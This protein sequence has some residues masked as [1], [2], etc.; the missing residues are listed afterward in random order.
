MIEFSFAC[1]LKPLVLNDQN[2]FVFFTRKIDPNLPRD[3]ARPGA[4]RGPGKRQDSPA[5]R[6]R[7]QLSRLRLRSLLKQLCE[8]LDSCDRR[9]FFRR[10]KHSD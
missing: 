9:H 7:L 1:A 2:P 5:V 6:F 3:I 4:G 10:R 8:S